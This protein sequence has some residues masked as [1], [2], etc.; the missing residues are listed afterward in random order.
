MSINED[1]KKLEDESGSA[2]GSTSDSGNDGNG[3]GV[4]DN[5]SADSVP[6]D[7]ASPT[8]FAHFQPD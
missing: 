1:G 5:G 2:N 7:T 8:Y 4:S 6:T 3:A